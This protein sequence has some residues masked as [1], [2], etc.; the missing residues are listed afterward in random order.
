MRMCG[1]ME[2][3][4]VSVDASLQQTDNFLLV[5]LAPTQQER[6]WVGYGVS[7]YSPIASRSAVTHP[8][9]ANYG[10]SMLP[11]SNPQKEPAVDNVDACDESTGRRVIAGALVR[12]YCPIP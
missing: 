11:A 6:G 12:A 2:R 7:S 3:I 10:H 5:G 9:L 4:M 8:Y 1:K